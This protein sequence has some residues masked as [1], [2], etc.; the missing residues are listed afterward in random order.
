[1][2][3]TG[4]E[5]RLY[6][7]LQSPAVRSLGSA[8]VVQ[9]Q[10]ITHIMAHVSPYHTSVAFIYFT[11]SFSAVMGSYLNQNSVYAAYKKQE[12]FNS[13][14]VMAVVLQPVP[15]Q[16]CA[17]FKAVCR[18]IAQQRERDGSI[19]GEIDAERVVNR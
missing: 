5:L 18:L 17:Q 13:Y 6:F 7:T 14:G 4:T 10:N 9:T 15:E 1:M 11:P 16:R 3:L 2:E 8:M 19:L 12:S